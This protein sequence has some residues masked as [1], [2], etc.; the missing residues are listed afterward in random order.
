MERGDF[1]FDSSIVWAKDGV[2]RLRIGDLHLPDEEAHLVAGA[3]GAELRAVPGNRRVLAY[4]S[5]S[6][7]SYNV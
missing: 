3:D 1:G 2:G 5:A 7:S 6:E 4:P